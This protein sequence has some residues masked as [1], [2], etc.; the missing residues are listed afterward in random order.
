[1]FYRTNLSVTSGLLGLVSLVTAQP[2][3]IYA[4]GNTPCVAAFS[5]TRALYSKY[6]GNLYQVKRGSDNATQVI[7][8]K[9]AG[10]VANAATQDTFCQS[11][12]C[13]ITIIYDQSGRGNHLTQGTPGGA[14]HVYDNLAPA[15]GAPVM[16]NGSKAYG[17]FI[18]PGT[19]YRQDKTSGIATYDQPEG[20]YAVLDGTHW[21]SNCCFDFGNVEVGDNL[22]NGPGKLSNGMNLTT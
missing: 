6:N 18:Q 22:D 7:K 4:A 1:M 11:T 19:G 2:C 14:A 9:A 12:T 20:M 17:V 16:V 21:N 5:T 8:P 10:G 15:T 13:L 3:D